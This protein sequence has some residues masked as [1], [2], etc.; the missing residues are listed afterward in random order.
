MTIALSRAETATHAT[1][2]NASAGSWSGLTFIQT[3][4]PPG[5]LFVCRFPAAAGQNI[6]GG[7]LNVSVPAGRSGGV[8]YAAWDFRDRND[9]QVGYVKGPDVNLPNGYSTGTLSLPPVVAPAGAAS[10]LVQINVASGFGGRYLTEEGYFVNSSASADEVLAVTLER[11]QLREYDTSGNGGPILTGAPI[12]PRSGQLTFLCST[13]SQVTQIDALYRTG[14]VTTDA[15]GTVLPAL[16]HYATGVVRFA[17]DKALPG[18]AVR[19]LVTVP[20]REAS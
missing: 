1:G 8:Y 10:V 3:I 18:K 20:L 13:W 4:T 17:T 16:T 19:W 2:S 5:L 11:D 7:G 15:V 6:T 12:G 14:A 9:V